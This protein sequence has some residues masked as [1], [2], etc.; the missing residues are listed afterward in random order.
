M[1]NYYE[2][3]GIKRNANQIEIRTAYR[4]L[5]V[6]FHPDKNENDP[7]YVEKFK[8]IQEAY[9]TLSNDDEKVKYDSKFDNHYDAFKNYNDF[10]TKTKNYEQEE[11]IKKDTHKT[12]N[13]KFTEERKNAQLQFEDKAWI[14][15]GNWFII[16][17][18]VGLFMFAKY[19][20]EGYTNKSNEVCSLSIKS[21]I[22]FLIFAI[23]LF[24]GSVFAK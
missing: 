19:R 13:E 21:F 7:F 20:S 15:V 6:K 12:E 4:K 1:K 3:L 2:I 8:T 18:A 22:A 14:F 9:Q 23:I 10:E 17:G 11:F 5:A 24:I 16:P